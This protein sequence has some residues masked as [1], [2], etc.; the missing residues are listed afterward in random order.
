MVH[1][2]KI[3]YIQNTLKHIIIKYVNGKSSISFN[4]IVLYIDKYKEYIDVNKFIENKHHFGF[5]GKTLFHL[6]CEFNEDL[7]IYMLENTNANPYITSNI[8]IYTTYPYENI[9]T[10]Y[11]NYNALDYAIRNFKLRLYSYLVMHR[12]MQVKVRHLFYFESE[13]MKSQNVEQKKSIQI[14][15]NNFMNVISSNLN[16]TICN[17][18]YDDLQ[19]V[20]HYMCKVYGLNGS[21][22]SSIICKLLLNILPKHHKV[23]NELSNSNSLLLSYMSH[24]LQQVSNINC[25]FNFNKCKG[26]DIEF[27]DTLID[28]GVDIHIVD[29][30]TNNSLLDYALFVR[31]SM[32]IKGGF[33]NDIKARNKIASLIHICFRNGCIRSDKFQTDANH[34]YANWNIYMKKYINNMK[35]CL[36]DV[37]SND[38]KENIIM[39]TLLFNKPLIHI[40]L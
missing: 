39:Y 38:I 5:Y 22:Y 25:L 6:I 21:L 19:K 7:A 9:F 3:C 1:N 35:K 20:F 36:P 12:G 2:Y 34:I 29:I 40:K 17:N 27:I 30:K 16:E 8:E 14:N 33:H 23:F 28:K 4:D 26:I 24:N 13:F 32:K 15:L 31:N 37:L 18:E 11:N 10:K